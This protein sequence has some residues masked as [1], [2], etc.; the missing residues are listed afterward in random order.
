MINDG[1]FSDKKWEQITHFIQ[2][3]SNPYSNFLVII[4]LGIIVI[5]NEILSDK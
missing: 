3:Y 4:S 5:N 1:T 2:Y